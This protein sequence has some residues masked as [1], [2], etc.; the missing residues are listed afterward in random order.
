MATQSLAF[1]GSTDRLLEQQWKFPQT[2]GENRPEDI[3]RVTSKEMHFQN[4][5][6]AMLA[7]QNEHIYHADVSQILLHNLRLLEQNR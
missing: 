3:R 4:E 2:S 6:I 7:S 1:R 5:I